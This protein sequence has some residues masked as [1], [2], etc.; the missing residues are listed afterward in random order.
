MKRLLALLIALLLLPACAGAQAT[1]FSVNVGKADAHLLHYGDAL[2]LIDAGAAASYGQL[3][4]A[5]QTLGVTHLDGVIVTH[6]DK[7]HVG[8]LMALATSTVEIDAWYASAFFTGVK[9]KK[10]PAVLAAALRG[11]SVTWLQSGD[12]L[13]LGEGMLKVLAPI[14]AS[15]EENDNSLVLLAD[16]P[17]GRMLLMGDA[18]LPAESSLLTAHRLP[19]C[20][21]L[22]V[23]HHGADDATS[24]LLL[25]TVQPQVAVIST[26]T[27]ER[28]ETPGM[29]TLRDLLKVGAEIAVTQDASGGVL[30]TLKEGKAAARMAAWPAFPAQ[31]TGLRFSDKDNEEETL[32]LHNDSAADIDLTGCF[33]RS[34]EGNEAFTIPAGTVIGAGASLLITTESSDVQGDIL[35][36]EAKVWDNQAA[37]AAVLCDVYGRILAT[38]E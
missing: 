37:D 6:T 3:S 31:L 25:A 16:T 20:E 29:G 28:A 21:V 2:Y 38:I 27:E 36:P 30:V 35:W 34:A 22:K 18:E 32:R 14:E 23:G 26:S 19:R 13:P 9:E 33:I 11:Q 24:D 7:D 4:C 17:D 15:D 10:H 8:G 5:L 12:V 1:L